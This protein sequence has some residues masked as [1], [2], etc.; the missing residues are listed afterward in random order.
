[1]AATPS[2]CHSPNAPKA[3][4]YE[5]NNLREARWTV[6]P[7]LPTFGTP[8]DNSIRVAIF[9][10]YGAVNRPGYY[11]LPQ[12]SFVRDAVEAADG[13]GQFAWWRIYSGVQRPKPNGFWEVI[14]F[15]RNRTKEEQI[16]LQDG[17]QIYFGREVY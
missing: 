12:G 7:D 17:D 10:L 14:R 11:Y 15:T 4:A 8:A 16:V 2:G 13:L 9:G 1:M 3:A 5:S 6:P